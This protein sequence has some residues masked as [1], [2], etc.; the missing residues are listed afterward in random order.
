[1]TS[2]SIIPKLAIV[3]SAVAAV[4]CTLRLDDP[5]TI[6]SGSAALAYS[7]PDGP[8]TDVT[9]VSKA[10]AN[11]EPEDPPEDIVGK[12]FAPQPDPQFHICDKPNRGDAASCGR[13]G[14]A[15]Y[16]VYGCF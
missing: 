2:T 12:S 11:S 16:N 5:A 6:G 7:G 3:L 13:Q 15:G 8:P 14:C 10:T 9:S 4:S 1:M